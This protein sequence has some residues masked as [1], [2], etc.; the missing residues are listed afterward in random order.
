M[1]L[2][3]RG[4]GGTIVLKEILVS[5]LKSKK[6]IALVSILS[7]VGISLLM[8]DGVITPAISILSAVEGAVLIPGMAW[9]SR[10]EIVL[11]SMAI[12]VALFA[13]QSKGTE[14][15]AGAFG[16]LMVVWFAALIVVGVVAISQAPSVLWAINPYYGIKF[17]FHHGLKGVLA[18]GE[19]IL[20]A[21]GGEAL[22]ADMG[23]LGSRPIRQSWGVVFVAL[24]RRSGRETPVSM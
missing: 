20:C 5:S 7:F 8:G 18:L 6:S 12:A 9:L 21:T 24:E 11:I 4:E 17:L 15:V 23:H 14:R 22:Y 1:N 3:K 19:I 16:P 2:S 13:I 10:T